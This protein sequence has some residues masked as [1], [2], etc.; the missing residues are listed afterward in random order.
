MNALGPLASPD[1]YLRDILAREAIDAGPR[2]P[3]RALR[4]TITGFCGEL[5]GTRLIDVYPTGAF[6]HGTANASGIQIDFLASFAPT[7][8]V[9]VGDLFEAIVEMV[10]LAGHEAVRRDVS[11]AL[12]LGDT[13]VDIVP[14]RR[15]SMHSDVHEIWLSRLARPVKTNLTQHM[16]DVQAAGRAEEIR[17]I[18]VWRDQHNLDFPS[19]YLELSVIAAL[20]R[21]GPGDLASNVWTV[22]GY[23]ESLFSARSMLDP[24]NANNIL[25]D[26]LS[27]A[28]KEAIR[29]AAQAARAARAWVEIVS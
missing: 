17:L 21:R 26:Q 25:S 24:A 3:L 9:P 15:E 14:G 29:R 2:S 19:L 28:G 27:P 11:V 4:K 1:V 8:V 22:L 12:M 18:K 23:L 20:R 5:P 6:E 10:E 16:L 7:T 13:P